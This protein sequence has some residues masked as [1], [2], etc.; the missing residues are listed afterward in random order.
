MPRR[1]ITPAGPT[2]SRLADDYQHGPCRVTAMAKDFVPSDTT[3]PHSH[4]R[5]QLVYAIDG[6]MR[7]STPDGFW[8]LPSLRALGVP[9]GTVHGIQMVGQ[10]SMRTL[11]V[12]AH[13]ANTLGTPCQ[14]VEVGGQRGGLDRA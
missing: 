3:G 4:P 9:P 7:V 10:V 14:V 13:A 8:T 6:V 1:L 2:R 11:Y 5:G 12:R